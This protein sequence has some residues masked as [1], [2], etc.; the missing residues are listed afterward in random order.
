[1]WWQYHLLWGQCETW[2]CRSAIFTIYE[3]VTEGFTVSDSNQ[4]KRILV[5]SWY[6]DTVSKLASF[7]VPMEVIPSVFQVPQTQQLSLKWIAG[8]GAVGPLLY[9]TSIIQHIFL[10][11]CQC[12]RV[13]ITCRP[14]AWRWDSLYHHFLLPTVYATVVRLSRCAASWLLVQC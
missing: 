7:S 9:Y 6:Y 12:V 8:G 5:I 14:E 13:H 3:S 10:T 2:A 4:E 11:F 1:M